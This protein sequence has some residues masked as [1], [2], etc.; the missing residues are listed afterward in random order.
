MDAEL[1]DFKEQRQYQ[2]YI[3][4]SLRL[5]AENKYI[6]TPFSEILDPKPI[7]IDKRSAEEMAV[8][9]VQNIGLQVKHKE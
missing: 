9:I 2:F 6:Q 1:D 3:A 8:D 4:D 5:R 7:V